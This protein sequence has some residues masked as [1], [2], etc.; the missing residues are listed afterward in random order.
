MR[1]C[2]V[3]NK[4]IVGRTD[5]KFCS[6]ICKANS[7]RKTGN[8]NSTIVDVNKILKRNYVILG[9][10]FEGKNA[11]QLTVDHL[12]I[13]KLGFQKEYCTRIYLNSRGK[14]YRYVYDF[15]WMEFSNQKITIYKAI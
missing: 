14:W 3:C 12:T 8:D 1:K 9:S 10:L 2:K 6:A 15:R 13:S 4:K 5:K 11:R 7:H